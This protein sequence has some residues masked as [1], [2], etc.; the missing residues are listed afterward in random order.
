MTTK[1]FAAQTLGCLIFLALASTCVH[2]NSPQVLLGNTTLI[3]RDVTLSNQDFFGGIP[4]AEPPLGA[5][6]FQR[7]VLKTSLD[8][9][10]FDASN[11]G[12]SCLQEGVPV[13]E[14]SE[15]CLTINVFRPSDATA[16][17][18]LPVI[19]WIID[20]SL[21]QAQLWHKVLHGQ[22][23]AD[24]KALNLGLSDQ[25]AALTWVQENIGAFGGDKDKVTISGESAGAVMTAVLLLNPDIS[26][27]ARAAILQSGSAATALTYGPLH[28]QVDWDN[29]VAGVPGCENLSSTD[30]TFECLRSVN[31][32]AIFDGLVI[33]QNEITERIPWSTTIDGMGG[34]MPELPSLLFAKGIF[35]KMSFI[36]GDDL[37]EVMAN[38]SPPAVSEPQVKKTVAQ[39][40]A[41][42]PEIPALGSPFN[43]EMT[44]SVLALDLEN[45]IKLVQLLGICSSI[46]SED[47]GYRQRANAGVKTYVVRLKSLVQSGPW[48]Q[49]F[50]YL[51]GGVQNA[52]ASDTVLSAAIIDYW[53]SFATSLTP[54]DGKG[55]SRPTWDQYTPQNPVLIQ[56]NGE[57]Q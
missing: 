47:P 35:A 12:F 43:T 1:M 31:T 46:R 23:A 15:D 42:Y 14:L 37:D 26:K 52:T 28:R 57:I 41:L 36:A 54:N 20:P 17:A 30:N 33:A 6:R 11:F 16:N 39:L 45:G 22:E 10:E 53:V 24:R 5:L 25:I 18:S 4:Y 48:G 27:F 3:G 56:L 9:A 2:A 34:F 50:N 49:N 19:F 44:P 13:S 21:M 8:T 40:V 38:F 51:Y 29:F 7:P 55:V 32:T